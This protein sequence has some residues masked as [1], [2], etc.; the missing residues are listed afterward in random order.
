M[1]K[2][3]VVTV[4]KLTSSGGVSA[5]WNALLP[6]LQK[7]ETFDIHTLEI[8][9]NSNPLFGAVVDQYRFYKTLKKQKQ[10]VCLNPSLGFKSFFRDG[11]FAMQLAY[12]G[13]DFVAFFHGW[14]TDFQELVTKRYL[15]F[16][17]RS[18]AKAHTLFV[19]STAVENTLRCWGYKGNIVLETTAVSE[20]WITNAKNRLVPQKHKEPIRILFLSRLI[21]EK[22]IYETIDAFKSLSET[23]L[24]ITLIIAGSGDA[25]D[26]AV[27]YAKDY[28]AIIFKGHVQGEDKAALLQSCDIYCLPSYTEGLPTTVL[29]AMF[30]GL[31]VVTT[32]VGGL[33]DFFED[34]KMGYFVDVKNSTQVRDGLHDLITNPSLCKQIGDYNATYAQARFGSAEV[35]RRLMMHL[36]PIMDKIGRQK[37]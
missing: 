21:K 8:G 13:D 26:G 15:W 19:L 36:K 17:K 3:L 31:P 16:F 34:G 10:L 28:P 23:T 18:F 11:A 25:Y 33:I 32:P 24:N 2:Q 14:D 5:Y 7:Q 4:P 12:K 35:A 29:E 6:E 20:N 27:A 37:K 22:G 30:F 1:N 9:G